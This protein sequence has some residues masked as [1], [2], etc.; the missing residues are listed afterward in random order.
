M[1]P[2]VSLLTVLLTLSLH[3]AED[4]LALGV[5]TTDPLTPAEQQTKFQLPPG[6]EIQL[7][8]TEPDINKPMNLAFDAAGR[9]WVTTS[10]EYPWAAPTNAPG[11]DRLM[12][13]E[14]FGPD[15]RARKITEFAGGLNI[16][17]GIY[18]FR[19]PS[20][21][22]RGS[23]RAPSS[24]N[25]AG[26]AGA[27]PS[28]ETW[29]AIV[30]SIPHIWLFEDTDGDGKADK[31]TPLYGPFDYTRDTHGN[32]ASFTRGF[33][34]WLYAT[35]GFNNDSR[36]TGPDGTRHHFN[37]GNTYRMRV[38]GTRLE[39]HTWGQVNPY[40][41]TWDER[42]NLYSSDCHS[43]PIYQLLAGG[44]YPSF[45]KPHD[46]L[47]F[48]P[49]MME[50]AHGSTAIDGALYYSDDLW[51]EEYKDNFFIG[52]VMTSRLNRDRIEFVGST[53]KAVEQPDFVTTT[54]P[55]FRPVHNI[56]GPDGALYIADFYNRIIGHYEVPLTHP[57]RDRERGRIWRVVYTGE[58]AKQRAAGSLPANPSSP[59]LRSAALPED[60]AGL[61]QEL[62]SP[63]LTRR[64]L[65]MNEI[66]DRYG[67]Q[68]TRRLTQP[69]GQ[70]T[71]PLHAV[72]QAWMLNRLGGLDHPR[73]EAELKH[74]NALRRTHAF[75]ILTERGFSSRSKPGSSGTVHDQEGAAAR[76]AA[77]Q[78]LNDTDSL[79][80]RCAAEALGVW[81]DA[82][83]VQPLLDALAAANPEDT[84]LVYVLRKAL[85]DQLNDDAIF[86]EV[87]GRQLSARD[88][89]AIADVAVA[90]K[91]EP[92]GSFLIKHR[93]SF[94]DDADLS[95]RALQ[96][97]ASYA[98][99]VALDE[100]AAAI[101]H[102]SA[103]DLDFQL[104]L[105]RAIRDGFVRRGVG[106]SPVLKT[107]AGKL[108]LQL[109]DSV[110]GSSDWANEPVDDTANPAN[111]WG[112]NN[113]V[114]ADTGRPARLLDSIVRGEPLTGRLISRPFAAPRQLKFF[115]AGHDGYPDKPMQGKNLVQ[116]RDVASGEILATAT[117]PRD[118][119]AKGITWDLSAHAGKQ[120]RIEAIDSDNATAYAW[121][122]FGR[123]EPE[124]VAFPTIAP[125]TVAE[126]QIAAAELAG[127][128][129][130]VKNGSP[131]RER[132]AG[133]VRNAAA[134]LMA[135][136]AALRALDPRGAGTAE[137]IADRQTPFTWKTRLLDA[138]T[139]DDPQAW[140]R[141]RANVFK[142]APQR[143]QV[144]V[145]QLGLDSAP[146]A[147]ALVTAM[148]AG[149]VS[150]S[151]LRDQPLLGKL[152]NVA[153]PEVRERAQ[154]LIAALPDA[155]ATIQ[156]LIDQRR[157]DFASARPDKEQG[158][159]LY[160]QLCAVCHQLGG[161]GTLV[162]PQLD[163]IGNRGIERLLE[164]ILDPNRN[165]DH[166]FAT[167]TL[168]LKNG[169]V[170]SGLFRRE[171]G[172]VLVL[173]NAAGLEFTIPKANV[174]ERRET[175]TS[176]MPANFG[177]A[178]TSDQLNNLLGY[179][180]DQK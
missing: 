89:R 18:P 176:L 37:S 108:S 152:N 87:A 123:F 140:Q 71:N 121:L 117:P 40:G 90:V 137:L 83:N 47:G 169:D 168:I 91:S 160:T 155:D 31:R 9:L 49:T 130:D 86:R 22:G 41:L 79:V 120:V 143:V 2:Y 113:R 101:Q 58:R 141:A 142:E 8:A 70:T 156:R 80:R 62:G 14:D 154:K 109:L 106:L 39:Q 34:G 16:P 167:T 171:E 55:W 7:V 179:V 26:S 56:L 76:R 134:D 6:F 94:V 157:R 64:L 88:A 85:R 72:H 178:L 114:Q 54:D 131:L 175:N 78:G 27:E 52:N 128:T 73:L 111:P 135:R 99:P 59:Y 146:D 75:R 96:H 110:A 174:A 102:D 51:P 118:D 1:K 23:G 124:V 151:L 84:H 43:A 119:A 116:L 46:G 45:G 66:Q 95:R 166:A 145:A 3:A 10:I 105:F 32:Q 36:F 13:F 138:A 42:G 122:A 164:D 173:A 50:H 4:E 60:L 53:P 161:Q 12:I 28:H 127:V 97:A 17:I 81:R 38:E 162:G 144:R 100:L 82:G 33:D 125:A 165:V 63:S 44:W 129:D 11:R 107:W 65:A 57:G 24:S 126:R 77:L 30:W 21:V 153:T 147:L 35:H 93:Q 19:S 25:A 104:T 74:E 177:E 98:P 61:I 67:D 48:A 15:G 163:G 172:A 158:R 115:L 170:E 159:Q 132:L 136:A 5:R 149:S 92:A 68:A 20:S 103:G 133:L 148:E 112:F 69:P 180:L 29:K 150:P 139:A